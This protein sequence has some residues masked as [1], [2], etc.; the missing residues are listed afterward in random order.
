MKTNR[1]DYYLSV[2]GIERWRLRHAPVMKP[3]KTTDIYHLFDLTE[4]LRV[5]ILVEINELQRDKEQE[6]LADIVRALNFTCKPDP[7][8][9]AQ[10]TIPAVLLGKNLKLL[11][12]LSSDNIVKTHS[13]AEMLANPQLK[14]IV[15]RAM[16][17]LK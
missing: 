3:Q 5:I 7:V 12:G 9:P 10:T 1:N 17:F 6:L 8:V 15:W 16:D 11:S 2:M 14:R 13:L 4:N